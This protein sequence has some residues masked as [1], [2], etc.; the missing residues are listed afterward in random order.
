MVIIAIY[1]CGFDIC[2][3]LFDCI[4]LENVIIMAFSD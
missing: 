2:C 3:S 1:L 4:R